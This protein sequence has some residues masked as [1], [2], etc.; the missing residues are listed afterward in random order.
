MS[1]VIPVSIWCEF[2]HE[3][4]LPEYAT[5]GA[6]GMDIRANKSVTI[7]PNT[8]ELIPTGIFVSIPIGYEIQ[9]RPRSGLSLKTPLRIANSPGTIDND[10]RGEVGIIAHNTSNNENVEIALGDRIAQ[11]VLCEVP[12]FMWK[13]LDTKDELQTSDRGHG[14]FGHTGIN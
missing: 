13:V 14:G 1:K 3:F 4:G 11:M 2:N 5:S 7:P 12:Y 8:T 9:I 10:Y 6:S